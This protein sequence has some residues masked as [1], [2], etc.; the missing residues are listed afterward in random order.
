[1]VIGALTGAAT[2]LVLDLGQRG[3]EEVTALG[4]AAVD[5]MP[6]VAGRVRQA[7]SDVASN[8]PEFSG[9]SE[10]SAQAKTMT[11]DRK[12]QLSEVLSD[13][14]QR[15]GE[16]ANE[17]KAKLAESVGRVKDMADRT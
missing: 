2:G 7:V 3:A 6:E 8:I 14:L 16:A 11:S 5:R 4:S 1:M 10:L 17:G 15:A 13:G 9:T 12:D